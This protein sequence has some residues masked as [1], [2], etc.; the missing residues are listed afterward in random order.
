[1]NFRRE[2]VHTRVVISA[3][4]IDEAVRRLVDAA[5]PTRVIL[6]G[7]YARGS[8]DD[9][10]DL[11]FLVVLDDVVSRRREMVR[12]RNVLRPLRIPA[13]VLVATEDQIVD[14]GDVAGTVL[15]EALLQGR[16]VYDAA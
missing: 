3:D 12:L 15:H 16:V 10:S 7:S 6:F 14:W 2:R 1:M 8:A 4:I 9:D 11:D 5:R 13:D